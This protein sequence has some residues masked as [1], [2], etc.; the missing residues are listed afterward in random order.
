M[1][2]FN[3]CANYCSRTLAESTANQDKRILPFTKS[4]EEV[5]LYNSTCQ[6][7][8]RTHGTSATFTQVDLTIDNGLMIR[9][10]RDENKNIEVRI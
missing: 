3:Q 2:I 6:C 10:Y 4:N 1:F 9:R 8:Q 5:K 7:T